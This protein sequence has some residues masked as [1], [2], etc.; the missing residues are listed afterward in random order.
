MSAAS[1]RSLSHSRRV[2]GS[3]RPEDRDPACGSSRPA[4]SAT[5]NV[6]PPTPTPVPSSRWPPAPADLYR[7]QRRLPPAP[8][9][10]GRI[11]FLVDRAN[12]ARGFRSKSSQGMV[13]DRPKNASSRWRLRS[14]TA[15]A[16]TGASSNT[17]SRPRLLEQS[18][19]FRGPE[20]PLPGGLQGDIAFCLPAGGDA[21]QVERRYRRGVRYAGRR[22]PHL[23]PLPIAL[24][25][26]IRR[27][28]LVC[29]TISAPDGAIA[30]PQNG[31][32]GHQGGRYAARLIPHDA[33]P[34]TGPR[35]DCA[36]ALRDDFQ[37]LQ[38]GHR[39]IDHQVAAQ[40]DSFAPLP[41][42]LQAGVVDL[43]VA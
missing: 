31:G 4:P 35:Q 7:R 8:G 22:S 15:A 41:P 38:R 25:I 30:V 34:S 17:Y 9:W 42:R 39:A 29:R 18:D 10:G 43:I 1:R 16:R 20:V 14:S 24:A 21:G 6:R 23:L 19:E 37:H 5:S 2:G 40:A 3:A 33:E 11:L 36:A 12:L 26:D 27:D 32:R 28:N 13:G